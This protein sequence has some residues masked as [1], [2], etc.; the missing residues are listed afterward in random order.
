MSESPG[1]ISDDYDS[2]GSGSSL[3]SSPWESVSI[4]DPVRTG[5][6]VRTGTDDRASSNRP[7]CRFTRDQLA[8]LKSRLQPESI[9]E[10]VW[11]E[12]E[13][14]KIKDALKDLHAKWDEK[15]EAFQAP[16]D[17]REICVSIQ[18][19]EDTS[20]K[21]C[22]PESLAAPQLLEKRRKFTE[23]IQEKISSVFSANNLSPP[24]WKGARPNKVT[25]E[26]FDSWR[27]GGTEDDDYYSSGVQ[28]S[29]CRMVRTR[30]R[31]TTPSPPQS[32]IS[33]AGFTGPHL[34][35]THSGLQLSRDASP[36]AAARWRVVDPLVS[37]SSAH[38]QTSA[39]QTE[40]VT[41]P[42]VSALPFR[43]LPTIPSLFNS[44]NASQSTFDLQTYTPRATAPTR[45]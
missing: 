11:A 24:N 1:N 40:V 43:V 44:P 42:F 4:G 21:D 8:Y 23:D 45:Y 5:T 34:P 17:F 19:Y 22:V 33:S 13:A 6:G 39:Q 9:V 41:R 12:D 7:S 26:S 36:S 10:P 16:Y 18:D 20:Y 32:T 25:I 3:S 28:D 31:S 15:R 38:T 30:M 35:M 14:E 27:T 2:C 29:L 37:A